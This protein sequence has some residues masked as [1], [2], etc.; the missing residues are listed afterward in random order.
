M[1]SSSKNVTNSKHTGKGKKE[2]ST[3]SFAK[4]NMQA[5]YLTMFLALVLT[6]IVPYWE[7]R[8]YHLLQT[9]EAEIWQSI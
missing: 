4:S 5:L 6:E 1:C 9:A 8:K 2:E 7:T 3:W